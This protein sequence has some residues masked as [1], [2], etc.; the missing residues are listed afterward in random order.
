MR[1]A[2]GGW[3]F[4]NLHHHPPVQ[5]AVTS[6]WRPSFL[7]KVEIRWRRCFSDLEHKGGQNPPYESDE[8]LPF[9]GLLAAAT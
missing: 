2:A 5:K 8:S 3:F 1:Q 6:R 7:A 4:E 9:G